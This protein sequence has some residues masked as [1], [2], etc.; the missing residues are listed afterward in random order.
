[1]S[2]G[3]QLGSPLMRCAPATLALVIQALSLVMVCCLV[4]ILSNLTSLRF[5]LLSLVLLHSLIATTLCRLANM[6]VWW[7]WIQAIFPLAMLGMSMWTVPNEVYLIGFIVSLSLFWTTFRTQVPF[8]P[9]RPLVWQKV[10]ALIPAHQAIRM[11]DIGSGLGD[12]SMH[13]AKTHQHSQVEG[14]E[15]AP[16]PWLISVLRARLSR[17][18]ARFYLGDYQALDFA[19][20][21][22]VF[23]YLSPAAMPA[24]WQKVQQ[25]MQ[26]GSLLVSYEF[27]IPGVPPT[28]TIDNESNMPTIF[29]WQR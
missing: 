26:S 12:L 22:L 3:Y 14:I 20:Y 9:S 16:L 6:A 8:F 10:A 24:L 25:E 17:S 19:Q 7:R 2:Q 28:F 5:S 13:I 29:V 11:I 23:A 21:Q 18:S 15:I 27:D 1:M 4:Y